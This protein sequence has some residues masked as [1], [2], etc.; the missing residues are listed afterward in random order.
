MRISVLNMQDEVFGAGADA[1][2][3]PPDAQARTYIILCVATPMI[4]PGFLVQ[5]IRQPTQ[6]P[7]LSSM[8]MPAELK[9]DS[10]RFSLLQMIRL[11]IQ[12]D[13]ETLQ[14]VSQ[15]RKRLPSGIAPVISTNDGNSLDIDDRIPQNDY[16][17]ILQKMFRIPHSPDIFVVA[18]HRKGGSGQAMKLL[19]EI[20][21]NKGTNLYIHDIAAKQHKVR[22]FRINKVNPASQFG[23]PIA[24][25]D[26]KVTGKN[27]RQR[28]L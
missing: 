9:V 10:G 16:A 21:F 17:C 20:P 23:F 11:M 24:I 3:R 12:Q 27:Y 26:M 22:G 25:A 4:S 1:D 14:R 18:R 5:G 7:H 28:L 8:R 2:F 19:G 13:A 6:R 15:F